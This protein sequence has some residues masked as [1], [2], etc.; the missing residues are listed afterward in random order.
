[1][2]LRGKRAVFP[3][4]PHRSVRGRLTAGRPEAGVQSIIMD[5]LV[6]ANL[7]SPEYLFAVMRTRNAH[8]RPDRRHACLLV[9]STP[10]LSE[11]RGWRATTAAAD[12]PEA[13]PERLF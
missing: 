5:L 10:A 4:I 7:P 2:A 6:P 13:A 11:P 12:A 1:M 8:L 3:G 9:R